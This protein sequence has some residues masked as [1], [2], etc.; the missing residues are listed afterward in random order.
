MS[1]A[2]IIQ[3][4][5]EA[6]DEYDAGVTPPGVIGRQIAALAEALE[7]VRLH[8][9][10]TARGFELR[11]GMVQEWLDYYG[12]DDS[13]AMNTGQVVVSEIRAWLLE[14]ERAK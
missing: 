10:K 4:M 8:V 9:V 12:Q 14:L 6:C 1:N 7:G 5:R 11:L 3:R 2:S 13:Q